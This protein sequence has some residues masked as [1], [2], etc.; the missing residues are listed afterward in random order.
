MS[1]IPLTIDSLKNHYLLDKVVGEGTFSKVVK[2]RRIAD[3]ELA[4]LKV[5]K[6][7]LKSIL[8][9]DFLRE[10]QVFKILG[11]HPNIIKANRFIYDPVTSMFCIDM[12]LMDIN[13]Y[14]YLS[15]KYITEEKAKF[16]VFSVLQGL[17]YMHSKGFFHRDV[18]PENILISGDAAIIKIADLGSC[19]KITPERRPLTQYIATRWYRAPEN[20]LTSG[21]YDEKMDIWG[22]SCIL[23]ELLTKKALFPGKNAVEQIS[24]I[25][26]AIGS[27]TE[28]D[29]LE[30]NRNQ[31]F[32]LPFTF[33]KTQG[34]G[35]RR[36]FLARPSEDCLNFL[37]D[38]LIYSP[39]NRPSASKLLKH[40]FLVFYA[41]KKLLDVK[42]KSSEVIHGTVIFF[43]NV[44]A[45]F[46]RPT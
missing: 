5:F 12:E 1:S 35:I 4:A 45:I 16:I 30:I 41:Q 36:L 34:Y 28:R 18:K 46:C 22:L 32:T 2:T 23:Y 9:I 21:L 13:L 43:I 29:L 3:E 42:S 11:D 26:K 27:P 14:D 33:P 10:V 6:K 17:E 19:A 40:P 44:E 8:D 31:Y 39:V 25:H 37:E 20:L 15:R 24:L 7:K 38:T